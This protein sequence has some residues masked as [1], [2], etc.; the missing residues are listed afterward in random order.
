[1][2]VFL[3]NNLKDL[4]LL[5][6]TDLHFGGD[7][8]IQNEETL[9]KLL[10]ENL[11]DA[12]NFLINIPNHDNVIKPIEEIVIDRNGLEK[13]RKNVDNSYIFSN[14]KYYSGY[15]MKFLKNART[16]ISAYKENIPYEEKVIYAKQLFSAL[17]HL[18]QYLVIGD[19]HPKNILLENNN[20]YITDLDN[21][22]KLNERFKAIDC[23]YNI[24]FLGKYGNNKQ[25]D[26]IKM[27]LEL[28]GFILEIDFS[29]FI[30]RYGYSEFYEIFT[31]Y[32]LPDK[33]MNFFKQSHKFRN[34]RNP[35]EELYNFEEFITPEI[36]ERKRIYKNIF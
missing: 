5:N 7:I 22:R 17:K 6:E 31:S 16:L 21:S 32:P 20:A 12:I 14:E 10:Y 28:L 34:S 3:N 2:A 24:S 4:K 18:H 26:I 36:L 11:S 1:M 15:C 23:Y 19:I 27:Y 9:I 29:K 33:V 35:D 25:T 13:I 8:F 30:R